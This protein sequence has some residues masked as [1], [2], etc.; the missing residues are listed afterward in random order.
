VA[1]GGP[2]DEVLSQ[3]LLDYY[4]GLFDRF[5]GLTEIDELALVKSE[6]ANDLIEKARARWQRLLTG[7]L[8]K[9]CRSGDFDTGKAGVSIAQL[10][11]LLRLAPLSLKEDGSSR[12]RYRKQLSNLAKVVA[13][14]L[15][16]S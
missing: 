4:G 7:L 6:H 8:R 16:T 12:A 3:V 1:R 2:F 15:K 5:H 13:A 14:S 9:L 11:D 10:V